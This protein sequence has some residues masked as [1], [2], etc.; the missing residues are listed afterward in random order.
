M[1]G[2]EQPRSGPWWRGRLAVVALGL[3]LGTSSAVFAVSELT[4]D[5][6]APRAED[7]PLGH[8]ATEKV[9]EEGKRSVLLEQVVDGLTWRIVQTE[10]ASGVVCFD[11][12]AFDGEAHP[13]GSTGGC[14]WGLT[15]FDGYPAPLSG[16]LGGESGT[17]LVFA[18]LVPPSAD[19]VE[20]T[21]RT[22]RAISATVVN[23]T[24]L[25][26]VSVG[27]A[28]THDELDAEIAMHAQAFDGT[29]TVWSWSADS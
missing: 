13:I 15:Q 24:Y 5:G 6:A 18:G 3:V 1:N 27:P 16:G 14:G 8:T 17:Y 2:D 10:G 11:V 26:V 23:G 20:L 19:R 25:G 22:G 21:T 7:G 28:A 29:A 9:R 4:G 12:E